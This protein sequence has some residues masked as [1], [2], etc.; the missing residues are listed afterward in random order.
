MLTRCPASGHHA[1][2]GMSVLVLGGTRFIG[3]RVVERLVASGHE[4]AVF[5]RGQTAAPLPAGVRHVRGGRKRLTDHAAEF[6]PL[7]PDM[8]LD[9]I[10][11]TEVDARSLVSTFRG[12]TGRVVVLSSGDV[13]RA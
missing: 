1:E 3:P 12:V 6:R 8:V 10:A 9:M 7:A 11:L 5:H 4:V 13:Y 2:G